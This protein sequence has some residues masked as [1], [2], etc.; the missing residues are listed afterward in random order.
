MDSSLIRTETKDMSREAWLKWRNRGLGASEVATIMGLN[1]YKAPVQLFYEKIGMIQPKD[2]NNP[3]TFMGR[4]MEG[5][6]ARLWQYWDGTH[7]SMMTNHDN[8]TIIRRCSRV[9]AFVQNPKYPWLFVSLDRRINKTKHSPEGALECK[10]MG[11]NASRMWE[12]G[13]PPGYVIQVQTQLLVCKF[14]F[15]EL[16]SLTGGWKMD[17]YPFEPNKAIF[18][19]V[20]AITRDFWNRVERGRSLYAQICHHRATMNARAVDEAQAELDSLEP[21]PD[22]SEAY[23]NYLSE[24]FKGKTTAGERDGT[25]EELALAVR[26]ASR[27]DYIKREEAGLQEIENKIKRSM[28]DMT[29][30]N[31]GE[32]GFVSYKP[33][34]KGVRRLVN[35]VETT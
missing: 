32:N 5:E 7:D 6:I 12:H 28:G 20:I 16:A 17:V 3:F 19:S 24:T 9:N 22:G 8:K 1:Q 2:T 26:A 18:D 25:V 30:L 35:K 33:D 15:G 31:F 23:T 29:Y 11:E 34:V 10:N 13:V 4:Q 21:A 14:P 27:R